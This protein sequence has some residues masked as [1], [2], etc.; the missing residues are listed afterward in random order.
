[1]QPF[2][3]NGCRLLLLDGFGISAPS[4]FDCDASDF[5]L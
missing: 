5:S 2:L 3:A 4:P 1:M